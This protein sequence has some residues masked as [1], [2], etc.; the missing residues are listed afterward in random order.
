MKQRLNL[1]SGEIHG[2]D[3][4]ELTETEI[5]QVLVKLVRE[6]SEE[7]E[8][9]AGKKKVYYLSSEFLMGRLLMNNLINLKLYD[10]LKDIVD[11]SKMDELE[12]EPSLGNGGLGRLAA[13]FVDSIS[14]LQLPGEGVGILYHYGL[15]KQ[16]IKNNKQLS[17]KDEWITDDSLIEK[18]D[19]CFNVTYNGFEV[20]SRLFNIDVLGYTGQKNKL[21]LFD[22]ES[23]DESIVGDENITFDQTKIQENLT[24]FLYPDDSTREGHLLRIYQQYFIVSNAVQLMLQNNERIEDCM[25]QINDTHPT[26]VIPEIIYQLGKVGYS[27]EEAIEVVKRNVAYTNHTILA[28]ALE[29]WPMEYLEEV[30]PHLTPII[31]Y[32][33]EKIKAEVKDESTYIIDREGRCH[34]AHMCIHYSHSVNGVAALHTDILKNSELNNFY[35]MYPEK[36]NNK[37][38]GITFRR[39]LK[40]CNDELYNEI[41]KTIDAD[42]IIENDKLIHFDKK[43]NLLKIK[44][45]NKEKFVK[46]MFE[47][48]GIEIDP[49][50]LFDV[51]IKR[52]HEYKRQQMNLLYIVHKYLEI[53]E[54]KRPAN[55]VTYIFGAKAAPAYI[56]AQDI[57]HALS[58]LSDLIAEDE[59]ASQYMQ[60]VFIQ[61]YN[62]SVAEHLIP[63][64]DISEQISLASKEASGTGNMKLMLN[65]A[66]TLGT[67]DGANVEIAELVGEDNIYIFGRQSDEIIDLYNTSGYKSSE[68]YAQSQIKKLVDFLVSEEMINRGDE[69]NLN[70]LSRELINKDWFMT[71][72]DIEEY[73]QVK[74]SVINDYSDKEKWVDMMLENIR[75]AGKFSSDRTIKEYEEDIWK[76]KD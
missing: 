50:S 41:C 62:V 69:V 4:A 60:I 37:T 38:N 26:L 31:R 73:I 59:V 20:K 49:D 51:Q 14:T 27:A 76:L 10:D 25:V 55:K 56:I 75:H 45:S 21:R 39:W 24:L 35:K 12:N 46:Y 72:I 65:G 53:K 64:A 16:K 9:V 36:F 63:A 23:V 68:Y 66:I 32:L 7:A 71:L 47:K 74:D 54:G 57:I 11:L 40:G 44:Q 19:V 28:E 8:E 18:T 70:R 33:D 17:V 1:I 48:E 30:V 34:M 6:E 67:M 13:C 5:F 43:D 61:N 42:V 15:F 2:K 3:F 29:K 58:V 22:V 52:L